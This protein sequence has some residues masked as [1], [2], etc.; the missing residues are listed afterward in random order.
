[1]DSFNQL[2]PAERIKPTEIR[3]LMKYQQETQSNQ[4]SKDQTLNQM[5]S[6]TK[7]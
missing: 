7:K 2:H 4:P 3:A 5:L 1:M 6:Y